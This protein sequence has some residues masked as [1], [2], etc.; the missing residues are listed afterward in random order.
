[1]P[2]PKKDLMK[3]CSKCLRVEH[4]DGVMYCRLRKKNDGSYNMYARVIKVFDCSW[5]KKK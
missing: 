3:D 5:Y 4:K 1:M 2:K